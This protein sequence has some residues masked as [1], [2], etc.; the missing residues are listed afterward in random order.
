MLLD[1]KT[2]PHLGFAGL[3]SRPSYDFVGLQIGQ[4]LDLLGLG[5]L[6]LGVAGLPT[7]LTCC[8]IA[9]LGQAWVLLHCQLG[10]AMILLD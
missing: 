4:C 1:C 2:W 10:Q 7:E 9:K 8:W 6:G 5:L 3:Q